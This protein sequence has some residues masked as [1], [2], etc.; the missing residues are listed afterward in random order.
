ML[1]RR[2]AP[3]MGLRETPQHRSPSHLKWV[4]GH[5]CAALSRNMQTGCEGK[6]EAA[7]V[8]IGTDGGASLKP[9]DNWA[10]PLCAGHHRLQHQWGEQTFWKW[11]GHDPRKLAQE[12]WA[13]SPHR[14]K[15]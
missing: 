7:H 6:I 1:K 13:K 4:R 14:L 10:V 3:K 8:R 12:L 11:A 9:G 5:E 15:A 2:K